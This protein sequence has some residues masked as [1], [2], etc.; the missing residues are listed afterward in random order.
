MK[1]ITRDTDYAVRAICYFATHKK[2]IISVAEL[3][4][5]LKIPQPFLRKILQLL[6]KN[7]I[8]HSCK[9]QGGG[10]SLLVS[11]AKIHLIDLIMIFQ[12]PIEL[13]ECL[14][15][16]KICPNRSVCKLRHKIN[17][18]EEK[19]LKEIGFITIESLIK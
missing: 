15:K 1:L 12:G 11:P 4:K 10:F 2:K 8:L 14:F 16:K 18:I 9:G 3:V 5:E 7:G 17:E 13:N 19:V 6:N